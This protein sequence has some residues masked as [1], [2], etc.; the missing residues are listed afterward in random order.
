LE[1]KDVQ[2][3]EIDY[4]S[5]SRPFIRVRT[6]DDIEYMVKLPCKN[7]SSMLKEFLANQIALE[8]SIL[9]PTG[10]FL[11]F[12]EDDIHNYIQELVD[13]TKE[14]KEP[15]ETTLHDLKNSNNQIILFGIEWVMN[16]IPI[17]TSDKELY[18]IFDEC[19]T[20]NLY[21]IFPFDQLIYNKDRIKRNI[22]I[23]DCGNKKYDIFI[24]DHDRIFGSRRHIEKLDIIQ[25]NFECTHQWYVEYLFKYIKE[26]S[27]KEKIHHYIDKLLMINKT[28]IEDMLNIFCYYCPLGILHSEE[29]KN[30][31]ALFLEYRLNNLK[32]HCLKNLESE[33][34]G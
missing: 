25:N 22:L 5:G 29:N 4:T 3:I 11:F 24:I 27:K 30:K 14:D 8:S 23:C 7:T 15:I 28:S 10:S 21:G 17:P 6:E 20:D 31:I 12:E 1:V 26:S 19:E 13:K 33:C 9:T 32:V 18:K 2:N 16:T 34:Y